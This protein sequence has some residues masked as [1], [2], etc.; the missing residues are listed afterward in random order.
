MFCDRA[1]GRRPA[2][3]D[4]VAVR[5]LAQDGAGRFRPGKLIPG[6]L[7]QAAYVSAAV[8]NHAGLIPEFSTPHKVPAVAIDITVLKAP[9]EVER[10]LP[11]ND[12]PQTL[13]RGASAIKCWYA[14][15]GI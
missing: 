8:G 9:D 6:I 1:K 11:R 4:T 7:I 15:R 14:A 2:L 13:L 5:V 12:R 10:V 3:G